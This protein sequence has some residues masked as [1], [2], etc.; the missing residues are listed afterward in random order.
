MSLSNNDLIIEE[1][2]GTRRL[3]QINRDRLT[4]PEDPISE[5]RSRSSTAR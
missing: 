4:I 2:D 1:R 5:S 3:I